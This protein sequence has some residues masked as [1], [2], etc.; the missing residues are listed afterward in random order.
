MAL[1]QDIYREGRWFVG[2][3]PPSAATL[4]RKL[5]GLEPTMSLYLVAYVPSGWRPQQLCAWLELHR[6]PAE[7]LKHA[8]MLTV[9]VSQAQREQG[10]ATHLLTRAYPWAQQVGVEKIQLH[11]RAGNQAA[12]HLYQRQGFV[13]EG[14]EVRQV[15]TESGYEDNV[16]MAKFL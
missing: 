16:L 5:R 6:P 1:Q 4:A 10:I 3:G 7:R 13:I 8:A 9:A 14:R 11:V 12:L 15:R 2:D